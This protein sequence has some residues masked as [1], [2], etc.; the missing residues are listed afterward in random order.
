MLPPP[1]YVVVALVSRVAGLPQILENYFNESVSGVSL[2]F[3]VFWI[4]GEVTNF[5]RCVLTHAPVPD[6]TL[7][8]AIC[9]WCSTCLYVTS[10]TPQIR[11][12]YHSKYTHG[13]SPYLFLFA[14][15]GNTLYTVFI[16][17]D[18]YLLS[19]YDLHMGDTRLHTVF[20]AQLPF[21]VGSA[22]TVFF[23][24]ILLIY[25]ILCRSRCSRSAHPTHLNG[26]FTKPNEYTYASID[27]DQ[28][29]LDDASDARSEDA[30][31]LHPAIASPPP[32]YVVSSQT[33][34]AGTRKLWC[35]ISGTF[36][37][38]A[39]FFSQSSFGRASSVGS[40]HHSESSPR[41]TSL[42]PS[43]V[44]TYSSLWKRMMDENKVQFLPVD[45]LQNDSLHRPRP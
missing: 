42:V 13:V 14:M 10:R 31:F 34:S 26:H 12:N 20:Y 17:S 39:L 18:L 33:E 41:D 25:G 6:K 40:S 15:L 23:D 1:N 9:G 11:K 3:L 21:L 8:G 30:S 27:T 22:G 35:G 2:T 4:A 5:F 28:S 16:L 7:I 45:F 38:L 19:Q 29:V 24:W 36:T 43:L 32:H 44:G 37:A